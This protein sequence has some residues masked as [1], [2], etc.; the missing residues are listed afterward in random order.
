MRSNHRTR[1]LHV[2]STTQHKYLYSCELKYMLYVKELKLFFF[3]LGFYHHY[4]RLFECNNINFKSL[5]GELTCPTPN[6]EHFIYNGQN[7]F[8]HVMG[9]I[10]WGNFWE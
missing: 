1:K 3:K 7:N 5:L 10:T 6:T 8:I 9:S 2:L 4:Q